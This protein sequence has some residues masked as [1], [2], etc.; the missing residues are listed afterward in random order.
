MIAARRILFP[1]LL[2]LIGLAT[3]E[4][5]SAQVRVDLEL[6]R[7]LFIRYEPVIA[8]V[9]ITNMSGAELQ[10][11][12]EGNHKWFSFHIDHPSDDGGDG[13]TII[14]PYNPDYQLSS[15]II[16]PGQSIKRAVNITPLYPITEYGI[17]RVRATI[18]DAKT[19]RYY[20]SNPPLN[21]TITEG[22][23]LWSQ[24]VGTTPEP[25]ADGS[26]P[27]ESSVRTVTLLSQRLP[28]NTQLYLR[29]EDKE[30]GIIYCT[31]QLGRY[32]SFSKPQVE[33]GTDNEIHIL[34]NVAPKL[35]LYTHANL[36]GK[37]LESKK[38]M[39]TDT[40]RPNLRRDTSGGVQ[41]VGGIYMDPNAI[42]AQQ[43]AAPPAGVGDRPVPLPKGP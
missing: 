16:E 5:A 36:D 22:T 11:A 14:P 27:G 9:T 6:R 4:H 20:S 10:L 33:I 43:N 18:Y 15:V 7:A 2:G 41:V 13:D 42:A 3:V 21:L 30:R 25:S 38:F 26:N 24:T 39:S 31:A 19:N 40:A 28:D 12:D 37:I 1:L 34:Q 32:V 23:T 17:Y 8:F 29:I 35:F